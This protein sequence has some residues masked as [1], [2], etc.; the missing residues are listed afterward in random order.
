MRLANDLLVFIVVLLLLLGAL[1]DRR[2]AFGPLL[3]RIGELVV[4]G[5]ELEEPLQTLLEEAELHVLV[6]SP[7]EQ[8][9]LD[10]V[11]LLE[12]VGGPFGLKLHIVVAGAYFDL[13]RLGLGRVGF[14]LHLPALLLSFVLE[15][16]I[17]HYF[18]NR[19]DGVGAY[20]YEVQT[21]V[22]SPLDGLGKG[23]NAQVFA[24]GADDADFF[25]TD[26]MIYAGGIQGCVWA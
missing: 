20:L 12:P 8:V 3:Y 19:G 13:D 1:E 17:F 24:L 2:E 5:D 21:E 26:L 7:Q 14:G 4:L 22:R 9:H 15:F 11:A 6:A 23:Q 18:S 16:T 25:G 10:P